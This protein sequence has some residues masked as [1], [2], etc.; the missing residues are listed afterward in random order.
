MGVHQSPTPSQL[1]VSIGFA[2]IVGITGC[3]PTYVPSVCLDRCS[4]RN[5]YCLL[6]ALSPVEVQRCD[7]ETTA[8]VRA[9]YGR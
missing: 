4:E 9:C 5:D 8:C 6:R 2:V 7:E 1:A 3:V